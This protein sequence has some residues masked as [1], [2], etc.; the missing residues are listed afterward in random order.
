MR[1]NEKVVSGTV[2]SIVSLVL[3]LMAG[4]GYSQTGFEREI[5]VGGEEGWDS[6]LTAG[7][8]EFRPGRHDLDVAVLREQRFVPRAD[9]DLLLQFDDSPV[10]DNAGN[11]TVIEH[12]VDRS[13]RFAQRGDAAGRFRGNETG[14]HLRPGALAAFRPG[15]V[16]D[17]ISIEFWL[18]PARVQDG[19]RILHWR[20][21]IRQESGLLNQ[22]V[23]VEVHRDRLRWNF[24]NVFVLPDLEP[25][26]ITIEARRG[27]VPDRWMHHRL[28]FSAGSGMVEYLVNGRTEAI[29]YATETGEPGGTVYIPYLGESSGDTLR[30]GA[31]FSGLIDELRIQEFR[32]TPSLLD[33]FSPSAGRVVTRGF[34]LERSGALVR[35]L[36][37]DRRLAENT[38]TGLFVRTGESIDRNGN[39]GGE[40]SVLESAED[41]V[42]E[43]LERFVQF[44]MEL[45]PDGSGER[46]PEIERLRMHYRPNRP[47]G[48]PGDVRAQAG[49][50]HINLSWNRAPGT[51]VQGYRVYYG[52]RSGEFLGEDA[53]E[54]ASP[55]DVGDRTEFELSG[56]DNGSL[57]YIS[58][59][60]YDEAGGDD[61]TPSEEVTA[62]PQ[63]Q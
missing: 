4:F 15:R 38:D 22:E 40:W 30:I 21:A 13:S 8:V 27:F 20:G 9:T 42:G 6:V 57:Y 37:Y 28:E 55:I 33:R 52:T 35:E 58:V 54:G 16:W 51:D 50:A 3:F 2:V 17:D 53:E 36:E 44:R 19:A 61:G 60:A 29:E 7:N 32:T 43:Q 23:S 31:G 14:I 46:T 56:L 10:E 1:A 39:V 45:Y 47:P 34:D 48:P 11:Y 24:D 62:R 5:T 18:N 49:D 26:R 63:G 12:D 59:V 25:F 41:L